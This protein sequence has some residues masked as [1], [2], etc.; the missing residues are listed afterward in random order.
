MIATDLMS[1]TTASGVLLL[2]TAS[3][4]DGFIRHQT[5]YERTEVM[6]LISRVHYAAGVIFGHFQRPNSTHIGEFSGKSFQGALG[7]LIL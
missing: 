6:D 1:S 4:Q 2:M 5:L 3:E 7:N